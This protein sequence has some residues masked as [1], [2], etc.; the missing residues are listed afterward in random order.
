MRRC[1]DDVKFS[2]QSWQRI[3]EGGH[4]LW[5]VDDVSTVC[6]LAMR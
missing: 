6:V 5:Q 3:D 2:G 1:L 4:I